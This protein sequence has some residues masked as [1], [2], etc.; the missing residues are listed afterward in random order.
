M[1]DF[2]IIAWQA[3]FG[4]GARHHAVSIFQQSDVGGKP[5][6]SVAVLMNIPKVSLAHAQPQSLGEIRELAVGEILNAA[7]AANPQTLVAVLRQS[8]DDF[9]KQAV[10]PRVVLDFFIL[11]I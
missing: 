9:I 2:H 3:L 8:L 7:D 4:G 11:V 6:D 5:Q 10:A 1:D